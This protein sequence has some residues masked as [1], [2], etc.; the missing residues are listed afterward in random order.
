MKTNQLY[1]PEF[2]KFLETMSE[3]CE[4][5]ENMNQKAEEAIASIASLLWIEKVII[6]F[7]APSSYLSPRGELINRIIYDS[8]KNLD[9]EQLEIQGFQYKTGEGGKAYV[10]FHLDKSRNHK[11]HPDQGD[12]EFLAKLIFVFF[13]RNRTLQAL[14]KLKV[15]DIQTMLPNTDG[16][17]EIVQSYILEGKI[18]KYVGIFLNIKDFKYVNKILDYRAGNFILLQY[19]NH[20]R[21]FLNRGE[22]FGRLGGDNFVLLVEL[23]RLE[24][25]IQ[26]VKVIHLE[27][28]DGPR[29]QKFSFH[30]RMGVM[31]LDQSIR[32]PGQ[33]LLGTSIALQIAKN[34][35]HRDIVIYSSE[36]KAQVLMEKEVS[37]HFT[38]ALAK[39]EFLV[40]YQPKVDMKSGEILG[41]EALAR[42]M[43][44]DELLE[45]IRFIPALEREGSICKLDFYVLDIACRDLKQW[46]LLGEKPYKISSNFSRWNLRESNFVELICQTVDRYQLD[47]DLIELEI[48]ETSSYEDYDAMIRYSKEMKNKGFRIS[49]DDFGAGYSSLNLL[50]NL[51]VNVL[52]LDK[53]FLQAGYLDEKRQTILQGILY[54]AERLHIEVLAEG[55]ETVEQRDYM[56]D[57]GVPVAQGYYYDKPIPLSELQKRL[58]EH[59]FHK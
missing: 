34:I 23:N 32:N 43:K 40:Y 27:L 20:I 17:L 24:E 30:C 33:I 25:F 7:L 54:L 53:N 5:M 45:P 37:I 9:E 56:R 19:V 59:Y 29:I 15:C 58:H 49:I 52:K 28:E 12:V 41:V 21:K 3:A 42:W 46:I 2:R 31:Y 26:Y 13:G 39:R 16:F 35:K 10:E 8:H 51:D 48:T 47:H 4:D 18:D 50:Q 6:N 38:K 57:L 1:G 14:G 22:V 11:M 44:G 55:I 36:M